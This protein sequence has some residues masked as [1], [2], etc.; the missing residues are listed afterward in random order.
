MSINAL[1]LEGASGAPCHDFPSS[2]TLLLVLWRRCSARSA[3]RNAMQRV[4]QREGR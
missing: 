2:V 3:R 4:L 1:D